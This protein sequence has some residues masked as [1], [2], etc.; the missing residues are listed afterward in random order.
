MG[1]PQENEFTV[2]IKLDREGKPAGLVYHDVDGCG[3]QSE[4]FGLEQPLAALVNYHDEHRYTSHRQARRKKQ[5]DFYAVEGVE[6]TRC[7]LKEG[8]Q[9]ISSGDF[10]KTHKVMLSW[11]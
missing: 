10:S 1:Q 2:R 6:E 5:C 7:Q 9:L 3:H 4:P 11:P 8:H